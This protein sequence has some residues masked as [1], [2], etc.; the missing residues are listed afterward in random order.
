MML[1]FKGP[2]TQQ[3][4]NNP[5]WSLEGG[6]AGEENSRAVSTPCCRQQLTQ[7]PYSPVC[8]P[9]PGWE[10]PEQTL[11]CISSPQHRAQH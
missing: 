11:V 9:T 10:L 5:G 7:H 8:L 3:D 6:S 4:I 1:K 2:L